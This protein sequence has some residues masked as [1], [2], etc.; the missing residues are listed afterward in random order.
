MSAGHGPDTAVSVLI[1]DS[2]G[3]DGH[4][5]N[6]SLGVEIVDTCLYLNKNIKCKSCQ[7][8]LNKIPMEEL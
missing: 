3:V 7:Y 6:P 1:P 8:V 2:A 4:D 5:A